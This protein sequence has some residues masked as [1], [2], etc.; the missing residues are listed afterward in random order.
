[1]A[2]ESP[3]I[4]LAFSCPTLLRDAVRSS[5]NLFPAC[6]AVSGPEALAGHFKKRAALCPHSIPGEVDGKQVHP[7]S[8]CRERTLGFPPQ[9]SRSILGQLL[10]D[11]GISLHGRD[12]GLSRSLAHGSKAWRL[13][14][15]RCRGHDQ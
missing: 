7:D 8:V 2:R 5:A 11:P 12:G 3:A 14:R 15:S 4:A 13:E 9:F 10:A 1:G 6:D